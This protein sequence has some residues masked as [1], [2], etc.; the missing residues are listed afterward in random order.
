M[1][2]QYCIF[3]KYQSFF[4][5]INLSSA[6]INISRLYVILDYVGWALPT[7]LLRYIKLTWYMLRI[8]IRG[9]VEAMK[10]DYTNIMLDFV[11]QSNLQNKQTSNFW[12]LCAFECWC[13]FLKD[14]ADEN[15]MLGQICRSF[16]ILLV[17][18]ICIR[19]QP[20]I[21]TDLHR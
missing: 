9:W 11:P 1:I 7:K 2:F 8:Y 14:S 21:H 18:D 20:R 16:S 5:S 15:F 19:N 6:E 12:V 17:D 4:P 3:V 10:P 13:L